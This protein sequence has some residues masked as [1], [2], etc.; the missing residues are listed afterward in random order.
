MELQEHV[1]EVAG[2]QAVVALRQMDA[3]GAR[4]DDLGVVGEQRLHIERRLGQK[5][6]VVRAR[7]AQ[8]VHCGQEALDQ[9]VEIV[10]NSALDAF[11]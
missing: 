3:V 5:L 1:D 10:L 8:N 4:I 11:D 2:P 9:G 7:E 6:G